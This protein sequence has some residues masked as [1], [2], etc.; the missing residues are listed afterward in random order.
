MNRPA[1]ALRYLMRGMATR[2]IQYRSGRKANLEILLYIHKHAADPCTGSREMIGHHKISLS[3]YHRTPYKHDSIERSTFLLFRGQHA[4]VRLPDRGKA[5]D[6]EGVLY[7]CTTAKV[8]RLLVGV[9]Q[10]RH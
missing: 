6:Y 5:S 1:M 10:P 4:M 3:F 2:T 8:K 9:L 7:R